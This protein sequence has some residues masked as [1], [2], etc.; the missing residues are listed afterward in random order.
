MLGRPVDR[1][2]IVEEHHDAVAREA[3]ERALV[4]EHDA[5]HRRVVRVQH[6]H[7]LLGLGAVGERR[8]AAQVDEHDA[9]LAPVRRQQLLAAAGDDRL[10]DLRREEALQAAEPLELA[11][12]LAHALL[13][14]AV[15]LGELRACAFTSSCSALMRSSDLHAREAAPPG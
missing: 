11:E 12:L 8:E 9:D 13:E 6:L 3:L 15:P 2:R 4:L 7:H 1:D 10:G 5:T 14:R